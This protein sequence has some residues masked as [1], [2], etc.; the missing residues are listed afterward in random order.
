M[1]FILKNPK[2]GSV[3]QGV[4]KL[5]KGRCYVQLIISRRFLFIYLFF[6]VVGSP[7]NAGYPENERKI[8]ANPSLM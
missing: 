2:L 3:Y 4:L 7:D 1:E 6:Y 5:P 8:Y